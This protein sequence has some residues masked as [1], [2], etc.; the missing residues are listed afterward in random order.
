MAMCIF[1]QTRVEQNANSP[2][3]VTS[4]YDFLDVCFNFM[5]LDCFTSVRE[6]KFAVISVF[7]S[8]FRFLV[9]IGMKGF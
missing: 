4:C 7:F 2:E 8:E 9:L 5:A 3:S 6:L 1:N